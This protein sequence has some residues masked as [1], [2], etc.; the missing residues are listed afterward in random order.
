[1]KKIRDRIVKILYTVVL[2]LFLI[3]GICMSFPKVIGMD[4]GIVKSGSMEPTIPT[5]SIVY[6]RE[7]P[8]DTIQEEDVIAFSLG[9]STVIHRVVGFAKEGKGFL[10]KGDNN[11]AVDFAPVSYEQVTGKVVFHIPY[12]GYIHTWLHNII[13]SFTNRI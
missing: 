7:Q 11:E 3:Y 6:M 2:G 5:G 13:F 8:L 1:M 4:I 10:T 9:D 12:F